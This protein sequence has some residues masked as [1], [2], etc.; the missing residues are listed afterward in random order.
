MTLVDHEVA[1]QLTFTV[2]YANKSLCVCISH[3]HPQSKTPA[4]Q[5]AESHH[6]YTI[7]TYCLA[8]YEVLQI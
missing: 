4:I 8:T 2:Y 7:V 6:M 1:T 3:V 5:F